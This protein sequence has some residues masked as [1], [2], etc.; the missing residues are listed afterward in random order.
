KPLPNTRLYVLDEAGV[1]VDPGTA[2]ELWIGGD[3]V[4]RGYINL[5]E[6]TAARFLPDPFVTEPGARMYRSGDRVRLR[7]DG[8]LEFAGR[9]DDQVKVRGYRIEPA[10]IEAQLQACP[11]VV[12]A[13]VVAR[14]DIPGHARL[15]A[16]LVPGLD[17]PDATAVAR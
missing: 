17:T 9:I 4:A 5:P 2:G 16:Y 15:V 12:H 13:V 14:E 7:P 3:G 6:E 11:G 8:N 1:P 10:E